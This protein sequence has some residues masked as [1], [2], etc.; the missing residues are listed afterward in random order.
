[1]CFISTSCHLVCCYILLFKYDYGVKGAAIATSFAYFVSLSLSS[2]AYWIYPEIKVIRT[3]FYLSEMKFSALLKMGS[4]NMLM[5]SLKYY[6]Y[7]Y[8]TL[9]AGTLG[10]AE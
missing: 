7:Q 2:T 10:V 5:H 4:F 1:M 3:E 6:A 8:M 9:L